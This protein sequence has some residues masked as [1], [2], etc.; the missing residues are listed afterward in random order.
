[1]SSTAPIP[2]AII[3][4]SCRFPGGANDPEQLWSML[5]E[6]RSGWTDVPAERK[7]FFE[8]LSLFN[9]SF[10]RIYLKELL[11]QFSQNTVATFE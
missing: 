1:M 6:G 10:K 8:E 11:P 3:G 4:M 5:A 7:L 2:I 9:P